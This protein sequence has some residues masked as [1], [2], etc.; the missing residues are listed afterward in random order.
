VTDATQSVDGSGVA[1]LHRVP[2]SITPLDEWLH[3]ILPQVTLLT[4]EDVAGEYAERMSAVVPFSAYATNYAVAETLRGLCSS[5]A[6]GRIVHVAETDVLRAAQLRDEFDLPGIRTRAAVAYRD[7]VAMKQQVATAGIATPRFLA[8]ASRAEAS[9]FAAD[10]GVKPR[11]GVGSR[12]VEIACDRSALMG[13]IPE[14]GDDL[15][16]EEYVEG[17]MLHADGFMSEG[18]VLFVAVSEYVNDCLA[19][20]E[21]VPLGSVQVD[22]SRPQFARMA[23]FTRRVVGALPPTDFSPF[24]L[25]AF[26]RADGELVFCEIACRLGGGYIM[27]TLG[28]A[29]GENPAAIAIRHQAGVVD[30]NAICFDAAPGNHGFLLVPPRAGR[31]LGIERPAARPWLTDFHVTC[32]GSREFKGASASGEFVCAFVVSTPSED[33]TREALAECF[34]LAAECVRWE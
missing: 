16:I 5:G 22:R 4:S 18:E 26:V 9:R 23:E 25:E 8:P 20:R 31:L 11:L 7:K 6:V 14:G 19:Y 3:P 33:E 30:G 28:M 15:L 12:S 1:V 17:R 21:G 24:H 2:W 13:H 32:A 10:T 29:I 27:D 34:A